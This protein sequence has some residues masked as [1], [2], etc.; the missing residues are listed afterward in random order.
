MQQDQETQPIYGQ[1]LREFSLD[2]PMPV[3]F[4]SFRVRRLVSVSMLQAWQ[5]SLL[6][7]PRLSA[8]WGPVWTAWMAGGYN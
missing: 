4:A 3:P 6:F 7:S 5:V 2:Q 1:S 8:Q